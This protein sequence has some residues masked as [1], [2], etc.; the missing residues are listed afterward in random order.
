METVTFLA[1]H[2]LQMHL[3]VWWWIIDLNYGSVPDW[4][5]GIGTVV[6]SCIALFALLASRRTNRNQ[7]K[8]IDALEDEKNERQASERRKQAELIACWGDPHTEEFPLYRISNRSGQPVYD[9]IVWHFSPEIGRSRV[10]AVLPP[11]SS[12]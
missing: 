5:A 1:L 6:A 7:Q 2:L 3:H 12:Y 9:F 11:E 4:L 10:V 8:Q